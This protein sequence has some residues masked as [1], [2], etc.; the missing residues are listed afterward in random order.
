MEERASTAATSAGEAALE[1]LLKC[2]LLRVAAA[3]LQSAGPGAAME[4]TCA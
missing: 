1:V 3:L 2:R 4:T